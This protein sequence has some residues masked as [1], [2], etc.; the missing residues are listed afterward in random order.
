[1]GDS[2]DRLFGDCLV[3]SA[4]LSY[5]GP[6]DASFRKRMVFDDWLEDVKKRALPLSEGFKLNDLLVT[7]VMVS[8]WVSQRLPADELSIQNG[9]ITSR[10]SRW[11]LC[12]D[13]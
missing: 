3:C 6:F 13:P 4:F 10:A 7:E 8:K 1:M 11:P 5:V 2:R 9:I 12:I